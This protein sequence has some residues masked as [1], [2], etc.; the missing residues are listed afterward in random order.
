MRP[1]TVQE[2][3][4]LKAYAPLGRDAVAELLKRSVKA[5]EW[6]AVMN[7]IS[8]KRSDDDVEVGTPAVEV[9]QR[10]RDTP[11]LPVCPMCGKRFARMKATG[12]CRTCHL[13]LLLEVHQ[14][15]LDE[16]VRL[17]RLDKARQ[18]KRRL[19]VCDVCGQ[20]FFPRTT[21]TDTTCSDCGGRS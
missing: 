19:R 7:G 18:D 17:R 11:G 21:S 15:Q 6:A 5:V 20:P 10:I 14:E 4:I 2:L 16:Q 8:L 3:K 1:W 13:D 12:M 9:L